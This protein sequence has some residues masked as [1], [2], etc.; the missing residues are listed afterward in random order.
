MAEN[1]RVE[2]AIRDFLR[3]AKKNDQID[4]DTM[5]FAG[6]IGLDSLATAELSVVLE[7]EMGTDP[8]SEGQMPQTVGEIL[9]FYAADAP[10][11]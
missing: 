5:L 7:D 6:G 1:A 11:P 3:R 9:D 2:A 10:T 4:R 8:F